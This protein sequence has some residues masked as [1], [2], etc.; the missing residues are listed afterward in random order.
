[1]SVCV[2]VCVCVCTDDDDDAD[3]DDDDEMRPFAGCR[4]RLGLHS[5]KGRHNQSVI[6]PS[7]HTK[8]GY[9]CLGM[10]ASSYCPPRLF[11]RQR[12]NVWHT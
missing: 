4:N 1:M 6:L 8:A 11:G 5:E 12:A 7:L 3:D 10:R 2:C 9:F